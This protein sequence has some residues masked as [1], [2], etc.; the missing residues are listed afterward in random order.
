MLEITMKVRMQIA[1]IE[2]E[3]L[4]VSKEQTAFERLKECAARYQLEYAGDE[5]NLL[6]E[7][8]GVKAA[9]SLF[10]ALGMDPTKTRPASEAL[11]RRALKGQSPFCINTLVD[12]VNWCALD[13]LLPI[14]VYDR[15]KISGPVVIRPGEPEETYQALSGKEVNLRSR[16]VLAD[17]AGPFGNP[18]TDSLRTAVGEESR[19]ALAVIF[20][21]TEYEPDQLTARA[22]ATG[23]RIVEF[24]AGQLTDIHLHRPEA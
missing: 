17:D 16:Y 6:A 1:A 3:G 10:H 24:C 11:L 21:P 19:N 5:L 20:T 22:R 7:I 23:N 13:S 18:V 4:R 9:R 14:C 15:D 8:E 12:V 2:V